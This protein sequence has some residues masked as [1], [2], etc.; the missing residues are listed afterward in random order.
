[1]KTCFFSALLSVKKVAWVTVPSLMSGKPTQLVNVACKRKRSSLLLPSLLVGHELV[2]WKKNHRKISLEHVQP[3]KPSRRV[4]EIGVQSR[5][6]PGFPWISGCT[7]HPQ[8]SWQEKKIII[9]C[10]WKN[11]D[12]ADGSWRVAF[13]RLYSET[14]P[15]G[16]F[17]SSSSFLFE[18]LVQFSQW[19]ALN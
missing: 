6:C 7:H 10:L 12:F 13:A 1:M 4:R 14:A 19:E 11:V 5:C 15:D 16:S 9:N 2:T 3:V 17:P 8:L 18:I